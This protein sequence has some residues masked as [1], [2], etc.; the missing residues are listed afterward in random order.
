MRQLIRAGSESFCNTCMVQIDVV[1]LVSQHGVRFAAASLAVRENRAIVA[2][3]DVF[4]HG[5]NDVIEDIS[6]A[7]C[8]L[9]YVIICVFFVLYY[10]RIGMFHI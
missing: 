8:I 4:N 6:L 10:D 1:G 9:E 3:E 5:G 2:A 7:R